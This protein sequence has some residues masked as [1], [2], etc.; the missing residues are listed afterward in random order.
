MTGSSSSNAGP[1]RYNLRPRRR[2]GEGGGGV[3][4]AH[5]D[6]PLLGPLLDD[7]G[8]LF[9]AEVL[10]RW[11][12]ATDLALLARVGASCYSHDACPPLTS[13]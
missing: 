5:A 3:V 12:N 10:K 8:E 2:R 6:S 9:E 7:L 11:L 13:L 1:G 4:D